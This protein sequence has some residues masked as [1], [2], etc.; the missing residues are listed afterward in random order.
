[1]IDAHCHLGPGL[2]AAA[3]FGA[4]LDSDTP[5]KLLSLLDSCGIE[6]AVVFAPSWRGGW[7]GEDFVD[8]TY[9]RA[10]AAIA[11]AVAAYPA[12]LVGFGRVNPK[13]GKGAV[14]E[15]ARC[16][17][18]YRFRGLK[19][20]NEADGFDPTDLRLLSPLADLCASQRAS[21]LVHT[22]FHPCQPLTF[23]PLAQ[24]HPE[25]K[26]ILGHMG[27]RIVADAIIT[28]KHAENVYL[29]TSGLMAMNLKRA[30]KALE[31]RR[32]VFGTDTP[33]NITRVE[34]D[35]IHGLGLS[36]ADLTA[37]TRDNMAA[38]LGA[39]VPRG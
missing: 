21:I 14:T 23:L 17:R 38:I 33:Y 24:A 2:R 16:F 29:E 28:A 3:P 26:L 37:V 22:G 20:D 18:E 30:M 4:V 36:E 7:D 25:V 11:E 19:L 39:D 8:P 32:F 27:G 5:E 31:I 13:Y 10:N 35:R 15:L 1:M 34:V 12:R 9:E 6:R